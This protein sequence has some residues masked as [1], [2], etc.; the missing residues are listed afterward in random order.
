MKDKTDYEKAMEIVEGEIS[1]CNYN[2]K[3]YDG[4]WQL[5][6]RTIESFYTENATLRKENE[7]LHKEIANLMGKIMNLFQ[8]GEFKLS[9]GED[10]T[11]KIECD[12]LSDDDWNTLAYILHRKSG[13]FEE[14]FSV[15]TGGDK[16]AKALNQYKVDLKHL[17]NRDKMVWLVDDVFTTGLS[18]EKRKLELE[19]EGYKHIRG[20]VVFA[21][22]NTPGW[23][24]PIFQMYWDMKNL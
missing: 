10:S 20:F 2:V 3:V 9:N 6:K 14:V 5:V 18:M 23:I 15:P 11:F 4:D 22:K 24:T 13:M 16:F 17:F 8:H 19:Q 1:L 12:F 21:R 7:E